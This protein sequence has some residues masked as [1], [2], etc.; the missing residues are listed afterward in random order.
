MA[1]GQDFTLD[2]D[3]LLDD[4]FDP[5]A[6]AGFGDDE[7]L[8]FPVADGANP[9]LEGKPEAAA[10]P[11]A[12]ARPAEERLA[13]LFSRMAPRSKT[14]T[15]ILAFCSEPKRV[16]DVCEYIEGL[17]KNDRSVYT[18]S[19]LSGLLERAGGLERVDAQGRP[20]VE[21]KVQPKTVVVDGVAYLEPGEPEP[22]FWVASEAGR[23]LVEAD[24]PDARSQQLLEEEVA[25]LPI[26]KRILTLCSGS[27][28]ATAKAIA[29]EVD[30]DPL[31]AR[32]RYYSSRFVEKLH[33]CDALLWEGKAWK[34]TE[35][36]LSLLGQLDGVQDD[37]SEV[38]AGGLDR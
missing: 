12:D 24:D 18:T 28:G 7:E 33:G 6:D 14:L 25:Y 8:D 38:L 15:R 10:V 21:K 16:G 36:G 30:K 22:M 13:E 3:L 34:A 1:L 9:K 19:D 2:D 27:A 37:R 17:R 5:L 4:E 23:A 26:I 11:A 32:P 20:Y 31:L 29:R 35:L